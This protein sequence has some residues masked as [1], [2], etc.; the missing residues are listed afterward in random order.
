LQESSES[1]SEEEKVGSILVVFYAYSPRMKLFLYLVITCQF[2]FIELLLSA[3]KEDG[4]RRG[5]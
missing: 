2:E 3:G 4:Y 5:W 1:D